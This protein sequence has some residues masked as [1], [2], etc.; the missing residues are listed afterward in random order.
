MILL[1]TMA[2][3][4][5]CIKDES[6]SILTDFENEFGKNTI[7]ELEFDSVRAGGSNMDPFTWSASLS[8]GQHISLPI[9]VKYAY[10][11]NL[12]YTWVVLPY[13]AGRPKT[14]QVGNKL[15]YADA[16]TI[17]NTK[18][19][20]FDVNLAP[21]NYQFYLI[22]EDTSSDR[23]RELATIGNISVE[24]VEF[25][26]VYEELTLVLEEELLWIEHL[27]LFIEHIVP[28]VH[29]HHTSLVETV[30]ILVGS[31]YEC[32]LCH[33]RANLTVCTTT[34][35]TRFARDSLT[36]KLAVVV[37]VSVVA[38]IDEHKG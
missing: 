37:V 12:K 7:I 14:Y 2:L 32:V 21:D 11:Q 3:F 15:V 23:S 30:E 26:I 20:E 6:N 25:A 13:K 27:R 1:A 16:D 17:A 33:I 34:N 10:P 19:L 38:I 18:D 9:K 29:K 31:D 8:P 35:E 36:C 22:A 5:S 4:A 28:R 24:G